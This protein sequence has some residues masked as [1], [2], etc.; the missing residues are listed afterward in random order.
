MVIRPSKLENG[1]SEETPYTFN[2]TRCECRK[3]E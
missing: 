2:Q 1:K 3:K